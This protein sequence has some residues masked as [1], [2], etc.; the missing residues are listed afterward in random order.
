MK[1]PDHSMR[2]WEGGLLAIIGGT[3]VW[4]LDSVYTS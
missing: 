2:T 1:T 4:W 3:L